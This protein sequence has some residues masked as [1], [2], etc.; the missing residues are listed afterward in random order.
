MS[1]LL[2]YLAPNWRFI[3]Y[4][5]LPFYFRNVCPQRT[6]QRFESYLKVVI[7]QADFVSLQIANFYNYEEYNKRNPV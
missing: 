2:F 4:K 7:S 3:E 5:A 1:Q 6:V